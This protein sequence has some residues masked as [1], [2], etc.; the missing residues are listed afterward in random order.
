M[1]KKFIEYISLLKVILAFII[2][3]LGETASSFL[4]TQ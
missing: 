4:N 1:E 2:K 3:I